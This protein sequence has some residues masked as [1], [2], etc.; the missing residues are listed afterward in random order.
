MSAEVFERGA[1]LVAHG[2]HVALALPT[3]AAPGNP[4]VPDAT[5]FFVHRP[6][7]AAWHLVDVAALCTLHHLSLPRELS[8]T[9]WSTDYQAQLRAAARVYA[10]LRAPSP[11]SSP[12]A[13]PGR[14][15]RPRTKR[16]R[17]GWPRGRPPF[18][19]GR[20]HESRDHLR[21]AR[22]GQDKA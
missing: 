1:G 6:D 16:A 19:E 2:L 9:F 20:Q 3:A 15:R 8:D 21:A 4:Q 10:A 22:F 18:Q 11:P 5:R 14:R 17:D 13:D 7:D 12:A